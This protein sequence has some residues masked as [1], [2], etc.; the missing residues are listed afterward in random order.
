M[1]GKRSSSALFVARDVVV[2]DS[3]ERNY[4]AWPVDVKLCGTVLVALAGYQR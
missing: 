2:L 3:L 1:C 4:R